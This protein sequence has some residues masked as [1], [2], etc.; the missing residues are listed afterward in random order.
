MINLAP[1]TGIGLGATRPTLCAEVAFSWHGIR[2]AVDYHAT[3]DG[4]NYLGHPTIKAAVREGEPDARAAVVTA[5]EIRTLIT[6]YPGAIERKAT[7]WARPVLFGAAAHLVRIP[8]PKG[9]EE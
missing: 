3:F 1:E 4:E 8:P 5:D 2:W 7:Y 6:T 9:P